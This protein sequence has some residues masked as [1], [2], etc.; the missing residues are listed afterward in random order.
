MLHHLR[1]SGRAVLSPHTWK[2][3]IL[4][5]TGAVIVGLVA[6]G[7]AI[8][9]EHAND[10]LHVLIEVSPYAP[11]LLCPL[12]LMLVSWLTRKFFHGTEGSGIPR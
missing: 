7:F 3:R 5:W 1:S 9:S 2:I 8:S 4:F 6:T 12:G 10:W 11:F